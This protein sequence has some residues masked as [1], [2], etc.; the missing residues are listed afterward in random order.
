MARI[1]LR[2]YI[3]PGMAEVFINFRMKD[4][5]RR[6]VTATV[7]TGAEVSVLPFDLMPI[8]DY[9]LAEKSEVIIDQAGIAR[10]SFQATEAFVWAFLEDQS[11]SHTREFEMRVWFADTSEALLGFDGILDQAILHLDFMGQRTGWIEI[12]D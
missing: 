2:L 5:G 10:Q 4:G 3:N 8:L 7:D 1:N 9:R 6:L 12:S 11:G